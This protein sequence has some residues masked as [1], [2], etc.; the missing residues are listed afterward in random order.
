VPEKDSSLASLGRKLRNHS[1]PS[2]S[3]LSAF[4]E[5]AE[6]YQSF[7]S[8]VK[9]ILPEREHDILGQPT[10]A[11]QMACFASYFEDRY[12]PLDRMFIEDMAEG[13]SD[14]IRYI[15]VIP[16]GISWED[17]HYMVDWH[18]GYQLMS[19]LVAA[20]DRDEE[21]RI[22]IG[23]L[24]LEHVSREILERVPEG[25]IAPEEIRQLLKGTP[26]EALADWAYALQQDTGNYFL[27]TTYEDMWQVPDLPEWDKEV[28]L[29]LTAEWLQAEK[30]QEGIQSVALW[31]E[32]DPPGHFEEL[33]NLLKDE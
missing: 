32:E 9:E 24:C 28:V 33:L 29:E 21:A 19:Y 11:R 13:Y 27:D 4:F 20:P 22:E 6:E 12:F 5:Q 2:L 7:A 1:P 17:Y 23:E 15:P 8:L 26:Y 18:P 25:G 3:V 16:Q 14:L 30:I 10:P 31:L